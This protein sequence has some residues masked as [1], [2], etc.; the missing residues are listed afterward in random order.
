[1]S[2]MNCRAPKL[3][4]AACWRWFRSA[5]CSGV[6]SRSLLLGVGQLANLVALVSV[7]GVPRCAPVLS[8]SSALGVGQLANATAC[9]SPPP[10]S[11]RP[12]ACFRSP[13]SA[14]P[15]GV[16]GV[17]HEPEPL[18]DVRCPEAASRKTDR[19]D[20]V[21]TSFQVIA[22]KVQ[23]AVGNRAFNLL[24]KDNVR[25]ALLDEA[26]PRWPKV[27]GIIAPSLAPRGREGLAGAAPGPA[28][29]VVGPSGEAEGVAPAA[30]AREEV[31]LGESHKVGWLEVPNV[32]FVNRSIGN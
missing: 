28:G 1:V 31:A 6:S 3:G 24:T 17:G 10:L 25:S 2:N 8:L 12:S 16:L 29:A 30:D 18:S 4:F 14:P 23:P 5:H 22:N 11:V 19:P 21:A 15:V 27:A 20:G 7:S 26:K 32:S 9:K 13:L